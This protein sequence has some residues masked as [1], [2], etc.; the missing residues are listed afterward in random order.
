MTDILLA[1]PKLPPDWIDVSVGEAHVVRE[2]LYS[3]FNVENYRMRSVPRMEY[4]LPTGYEPLVRFLEDRYGAPVVITNG[5]KQGLSAAFYALQCMG[6]QTV[7]MRSPYWALLP[8]LLKIHGLDFTP[9]DA[10]DYD[11]DAPVYDSYL[12]VSPNNPDGFMTNLKEVAGFMKG[13]GIPLIH[14]AVYYSHVYLPWSDPLKQYGDV[15]IY[16]ASKSFGL[17]G[18]RIGWAVCPNPDFYKYIQEYMET[19]T[20]GVSVLPQVF[21]HD[22]M[23]EMDGHQVL[24]EEFEQTAASALRRSKEIML[25]VRPEILEIPENLPDIAG[26]FG[27]FKVGPACDFEQAKINVIDGALFGVP[28]MVRMNLAF[29]EHRIKEIVHRLNSIKGSR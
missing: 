26:M 14:D 28:G 21:I 23:R 16:S 13:N 8:P 12:S 25:K 2:A 22:L 11:N 27:W 29:N 5:A 3:I 20:V 10:W 1:K 6:K 17:S 19:I 15:Q 9:P 4:P 24:F 18:L 7:G